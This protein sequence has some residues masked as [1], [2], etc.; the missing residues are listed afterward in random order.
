MKNL[1]GTTYSKDINY[2]F[3]QVVADDKIANQFCQII[4]EKQITYKRVNLQI[5]CVYDDRQERYLYHERD[6]T[7]SEFLNAS[8]LD[9]Y[10]I[11]WNK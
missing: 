3:L 4:Q 6:Y 9:A 1:I 11:M 2:E 5:N 7:L 10:Y 8:Y